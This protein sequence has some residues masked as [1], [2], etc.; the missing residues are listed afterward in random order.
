MR[1]RPEFLRG[2][3]QGLYAI[4]PDG[5]DSRRLLTVS[6][7]ILSSGCRVLQYRNKRAS[8]CHRAEQAGALR[9]LTRRYDALLI[10]ND[11]VDLALA[12]EADGVHL[13]ADDGDLAAARAQIPATMW[14]GASC[15][16]SLETAQA[17]RAAGADYIAF[18]SFFPSPTK[19]QARRAGLELLIA[20][21]DLGCPVCAIGGITVDNAPP[22]IAAGA[23][24]LAVISALFDA[25]DPAQA[26]RQFIS[27]FNPCLP[28]TAEK[29]PET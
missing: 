3:L 11:A 2:H 27:L 25:P 9:Q 24:C 16:Q 15:Y 20:G 19:P 28:D 14:L 4:T 18:G 21:K 1:R 10:V 5:S 8:A 17:A 26:T 6:E 23:D 12:V 22:L 29:R 7:Q 13:G